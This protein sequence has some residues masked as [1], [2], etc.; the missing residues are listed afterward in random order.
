[1][2]NDV[3]QGDSNFAYLPVKTLILA[4]CLALFFRVTGAGGDFLKGNASWPN[5][6]MAISMSSCLLVV[7]YFSVF[8]L[9]DGSGFLGL[10]RKI[11]FELVKFSFDYGFFAIGFIV[12]VECG[13]PGYWKLL[14]IWI[15]LYLGAFVIFNH[16]LLLMHGG[17]GATVRL[18]N[19]VDEKK[20]WKIN[21]TIVENRMAFMMLGSFFAIISGA[22][23]LYLKH[24]LAGTP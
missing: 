7:Y 5:L 13:D 1:M 19:W 22:V 4:F 15:P 16:V 24:G 20:G 12:V 6:V 9:N 21:F 11:I 8:Y 14:L 2:S 17:T 10:V 3:E 23:F 18:A